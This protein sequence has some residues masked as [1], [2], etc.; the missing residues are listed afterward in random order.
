[1]VWVGIMES[2]QPSFAGPPG[3]ALICIDEQSRQVTVKG[4]AVAV[5]PTEFRILAAL[6]SRPGEALARNELARLA[7]SDAIV[8]DRTVDV[9]LASLRRK[10]GSAGQCIK[11][12]RGVG[13]RFDFGRES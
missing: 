6:M 13:Y 10:L 11:A 5:T 7:I 3:R 1:M 12:V 4:R 9:H 8:G 2:Q